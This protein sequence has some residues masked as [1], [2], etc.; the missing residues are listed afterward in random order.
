MYRQEALSTDRKH[1]CAD[2]RPLCQN[3]R[4]LCTNR[5][6]LCMDRRPL[7]TN[8][9][10]LVYSDRRP[11]STRRE[12]I[13]KEEALWEGPPLLGSKNGHRGPRIFQ[14]G[15]KWDLKSIQSYA[16]ASGMGWVVLFDARLLQK[17]LAVVRDLD[18]ERRFD[19]VTNAPRSGTTYTFCVLVAT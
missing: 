13:C 3:R 18:A 2:G 19:S 11:L 1:L 10:R 15:P 12:P 5:R 8:N 6:S 17:N 7:W 9:K 4:P 16:H 14:W